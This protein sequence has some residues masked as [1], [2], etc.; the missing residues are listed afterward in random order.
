MRRLGNMNMPQVITITAILMQNTSECA[1]TVPVVV[2][3]LLLIAQL[4]LPPMW[5]VRQASS[6]PQSSCHHCLMLAQ[7][8]IVFGM[9][10]GL[11]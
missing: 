4:F 5:Q 8:S 7:H 11:S 3:T 10:H 6:V 2:D 9:T 1:W